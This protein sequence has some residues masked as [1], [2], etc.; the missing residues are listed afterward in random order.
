MNRCQLEMRFDQSP[1]L[2]RRAARPRR[3]VTRARWW[4]EQ[5]HLAVDQATDWDPRPLP[6][7]RGAN[8]VR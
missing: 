2:C 6:D 4:F 3:R 8:D 7:P 5:M 1:S